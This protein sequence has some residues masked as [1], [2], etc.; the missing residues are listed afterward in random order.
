MLWCVTRDC[1]KNIFKKIMFAKQRDGALSHLQCICCSCEVYPHLVLLVSLSTYPIRPGHCGMSFSRV[2]GDP[3]P[4][5][6]ERAEVSF[7]SAAL[8]IRHT[9]ILYPVDH[10]LGSCPPCCCR[11]LVSEPVSHKGRHSRT[12][13]L[14]LAPSH[15][16]GDTSGWRSCYSKLVREQQPGPQTIV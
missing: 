12:C 6:D 2:S 3:Y 13:H 16:T 15:V 9:P 7:V 8:V 10:F 5:K 11:L 1:F 4:D 14:S